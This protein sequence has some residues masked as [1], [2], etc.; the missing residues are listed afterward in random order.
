MDDCNDTFTLTVLRSA[1]PRAAA[2]APV[3]QEL[4]VLVGLENGAYCAQSARLRRRATG[5]GKGGC[6]PDDLTPASPC[7]ASVFYSNVPDGSGFKCSSKVQG[8][9][10]YITSPSN[11]SHRLHGIPSRSRSCR[12]QAERACIPICVLVFCCQPRLR[13]DDTQRCGRR[14]RHPRARARR[15][16]AFGRHAARVSVPQPARSHPRARAQHPDPPFGRHI[17]RV[18]TTH[19]STSVGPATPELVHGTPIPCLDD[20]RRD[21]MFGRHTAAQVSVS[22]PA[23]SHPRARARARHPDPAFGRHTAV[24]ASVPQPARSHLRAALTPSTR[25]HARHPDPAF[26]RHTHTAA[27]ASV[28]QPALPPNLHDPSSDVLPW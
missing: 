10:P 26:G 17:A 25:A 12:V 14:S 1:G 4:A 18:R 15:D 8:A 23:R 11:P 16:P 19:S 22:Q 2:A 9:C 27:R 7:L 20:T 3:F 5:G 28:P 21:P 24:R 6:R 13:S